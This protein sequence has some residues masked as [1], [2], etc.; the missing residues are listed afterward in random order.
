MNIVNLTNILTYIHSQLLNNTAKAIN[1]AVTMRNW[2]YGYYIH[3]YE[4]HGH[5]RAEYGEKVIEKLSIILQ[6]KNIPTVSH[7]HLKLCRQ[8]YRQYFQIGQTVFAQFEIL[9]PNGLPDI[10]QTPFAQCHKEGNIP[11]LP[12][13]KL[14]SSL[15][16]SHFI[17]L[18]KI[19]EPIKR[20][21][22]EIECIRGSWSVRELKRQISSL[23]Y[24]RSG[25]SKNKDKL[26]KIAHETAEGYCAKDVIRDPYVFEFLGI[27]P[28]EIMLESKLSNALLTK[29]QNFL[30]ELGKGFCFE[31]RNKRILIGD[32]YFFIDLVMYHRI[33]KLTVL[34][35]LKVDGF[36]HH[37][38]GQLN[39]YINYYKKHEMHAGDNPPIGILL[40]TSKN[41][42]LVE[43]ALSE[44]NSQ[45]F[46]SEYKL[47][48][49]SE[50]EMKNF[51]ESQL[52]NELL[53][54]VGEEEYKH[55]G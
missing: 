36:N 51:I 6:S 27:K 30:L 29:M 44:S 15:S 46:V 55:Q 7:R 40:C 10:G 39:T 18:I 21:F 8:F 38:I 2:L 35:E 34:I 4:L 3:E 43:Y 54:L 49:P 14:L 17:E 16:Y 12:G 31:A 23:Y 9:I 28:Q 45:L 13:D 19:S 50:T 22:Y 47:A 20:S 1:I 53:N 41:N 33:L 5:D 42:A 48:L 52:G 26:S 11:C 25:L 32:E 37:H 24:E